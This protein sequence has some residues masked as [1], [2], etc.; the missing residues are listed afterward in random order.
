[1]AQIIPIPMENMM[2]A[3]VYRVPK[4]SEAGLALVVEASKTDKNTSSR[5]RVSV[6]FMS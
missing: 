2:P 5:L 3:T 1:M 4:K 6:L